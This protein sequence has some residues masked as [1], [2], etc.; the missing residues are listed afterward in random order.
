MPY[1]S[2]RRQ[3]A[4]NPV[5]K[6]LAIPSSPRIR[7]NPKKTGETAIATEYKSCCNRDNCFV[8]ASGAIRLESGKTLLGKRRWA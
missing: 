8:C 7:S 5:K 1:P 6:R 4:M 2:G 3:I